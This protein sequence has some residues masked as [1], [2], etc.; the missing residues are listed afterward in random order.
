MRKVEII[1]AM[2]I[3]IKN[4][5]KFILRVSKCRC[6]INAPEIDKVRVSTLKIAIESTRKPL[7]VFVHKTFGEAICTNIFKVFLIKPHFKSVVKI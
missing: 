5:S 7:A 1:N 4:L 3:I 2:Y 6:S